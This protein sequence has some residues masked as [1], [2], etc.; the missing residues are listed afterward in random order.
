MKTLEESTE[1]RTAEAAAEE[2]ARIARDMH[3]VL[4]HSVS[5]MVVQAEAGPVVVRSAPEK[6]ERAFEAISE[7]GRDALVQ[8]RRL[9]GV[10]REDDALALAPQPTIAAL[11]KLVETVRTTG[12]DVRLVTEGTARQLPV[13]VEVAVYR[14]V[15][16][17]LTNT[18]KHAG[19]RRSEVRLNWTAEQL[20]I[21][22]VDDGIGSSKRPRTCGGE[23]TTGPGPDNAGYALTALIPVPFAG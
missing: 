9:L 21:H 8:L 20:T 18:V 22:I 6:A 5:V 14:T 17:A 13:D 7:A 11:T 10:L 1:A 12:L 15:Q 4:A 23:V 3:D 16:E 2:R 19:A